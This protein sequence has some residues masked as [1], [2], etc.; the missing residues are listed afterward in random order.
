MRR[1]GQLLAASALVAVAACSSQGQLQVRPA[2]S[3]LAAAGFTVPQK[4][5]EG[6]AQLALGNPGL[7]LELFRKALRENPASAEA[8]AGIA[9][10]YDRMNRFDLS[11]RYYEA[12]L[13]IAPASTNLLER[14][15]QSLDRQGK[16]EEAAGIRRE[17]AM[18]S[19]A[20]DVAQNIQAEADPALAEVEVAEAVTPQPAIPAL[21]PTAAPA[22]LRPVAAPAQV[23][24]IDAP[25][26]AAPAVAAQAPVAAI[27]AA[28][29]PAAA[30]V[31]VAPRAPEPAAV[32][33][34]P[35]AA[36]SVTI[37]LPPA[38]PV[39][40]AP[41]VTAPQPVAL[42]IPVAP[43][44]AA[45][46]PAA[47]PKPAAAEPAPPA[48]ESRLRI[49]VARG[50]GP[51]LER[52]SRAEVALVTTDRAPRWRS[53]VVA[54]NDRS[55]TIRYVPL[56]SSQPAFA[57][58]RLLN[59]ARS[60]GLAADTRRYLTNMGWRRIAIGDAS[61]ARETSIIYYPESRR[62]T[63]EVLAAQFRIRVARRVQEGSAIVMLLG[64][65]AARTRA[66]RTAA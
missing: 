19:A 31:P 29:A 10:C 4:V 34:A 46:V 12:A 62:R 37:T 56:K 35:V 24:T 65:D 54:R 63:A 60:Q 66:G 7:A 21:V 33:P 30:P 5:A 3:Q 1:G 51:R 32:A 53:Q 18:R 25:A 61:Q 43:K 49:E 20:A 55:T 52:M 48:P 8:N 45:P 22:P 44:P 58:V 2:G 36:A 64:R 28:A 13:A 38:R 59:A 39:A 40:E 11:R 16:A 23:A 47:A 6:H 17:I 26:P 14:L 57:S 15:A 42:P 41:R 50:E 9:L 27:P